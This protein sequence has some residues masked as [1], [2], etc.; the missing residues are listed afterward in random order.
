MADGVELTEHD[1]EE[2]RKRYELKLAEAAL[3]EA[4]D[5]KRTVRM[6]RDNEGNWSYVYTADEDDVA[7]AEQNYEDKLYQY[8]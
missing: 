7:A 8:Q 2:L 4:R 6:S 5:S 1:V 3:E